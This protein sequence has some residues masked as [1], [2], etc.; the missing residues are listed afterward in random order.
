MLSVQAYTFHHE[1]S[2]QDTIKFYIHSELSIYNLPV[3]FFTHKDKISSI[4]RAMQQNS[5]QDDLLW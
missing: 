2:L 4:P 5:P 1:L 3:F